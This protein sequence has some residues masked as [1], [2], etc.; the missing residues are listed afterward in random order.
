MQKIDLR[1]VILPDP[2]PDFI[3]KEIKTFSR[4]ANQLHPQHAKLIAAIAKHYHLERE[5][6]VLT[7]GVDPAVR[8]LGELYGKQTFVFLPCYNVLADVHQ[9]GSYVTHVGSLEFASFAISYENRPRSTL[10]FLSNPN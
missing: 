4:A 8:L 10:F 9:P 2:L 5:T 7:A 3:W 6:I 1:D